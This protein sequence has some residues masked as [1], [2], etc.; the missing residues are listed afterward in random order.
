MF[1]DLSKVAGL[2]VVA[3]SLCSFPVQAASSATTPIKYIVAIF[4]ENNSFDHYF[5]AYPNALC[6]GGTA[7]VLAPC[8]AGESAFTPLPNTPSVNGLSSATNALRLV[9]PFRLESLTSAYLGRLRIDN[10]GPYG[11]H[12]PSDVGTL[13]AYSDGREAGRG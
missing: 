9:P 6:P 5:G 7:P 2:L 1:K 10:A 13:L 3:S 8:T 11:S 12:G 4:Q